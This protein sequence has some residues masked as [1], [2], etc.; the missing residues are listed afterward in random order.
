MSKNDDDPRK[1]ILERRKFIEDDNDDLEVGNEDPFSDIPDRAEQPSKK[2]EEIA[3]REKVSSPAFDL[4]K[5]LRRQMGIP[6]EEQVREKPKVGKLRPEAIEALANAKA[7]DAR[8][9]AER[10]ESPGEPRVSLTS[11]ESVKGSEIPVPPS[12]PPAPPLKATEEPR[13]SL[14]S[15]ESIKGS[16]IPIPPSPPPAPP[17]EERRTT[18]AMEEPSLLSV[19]KRKTTVSD[20]PA[21]TLEERATTEKNT[22]STK[23]E[24]V[25][26]KAGVVL[27]PGDHTL[28]TE[29]FH[30][31]GIIDRVPKRDKLLSE[32]IALTVETV[33]KNNPKLQPFISEVCDAFV[34]KATQDA[35]RTALNDRFGQI[36]SEY[37]K[38]NKVPEK[39]NEDLRIVIEDL[40][41]LQ[42]EVS[43]KIGPKNA[44]ELASKIDKIKEDYNA[45]PGEEQ[46][47]TL[48]KNLQ[49][50]KDWSSE[51][52]KETN[53]KSTWKKIG[54]V[55]SSCMSLVAAK[56]A[57]KE[58]ET[59]KNT[60]AQAM[61]EL[62]TQGKKEVV[63]GLSKINTRAA[64]NQQRGR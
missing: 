38:G 43:D 22:R 34:D 13:V 30:K 14:T 63:E 60:L 26:N 6:E 2:K 54:T 45:K 11:R 55:I 28:I 44:K 21:P 1:K 17:L 10:E 47:K 36:K 9:A 20:I 33:V 40:E 57:G 24:E 25:L 46:I 5:I 49:S 48:Y 35:T 64:E 19:E 3:T 52:G 37:Q 56:I 50:L 62:K 4:G 58:V 29:A 61:K 53:D 8:R 32:Q 41:Q 27:G 12:P 59:I 16:E 7:E 15:R 18:V 23:F 31:V 39:S 42:Q 51:K